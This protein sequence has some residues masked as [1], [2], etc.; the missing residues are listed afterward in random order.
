MIMNLLPYYDFGVVIEKGNKMKYL[1]I[2]SLI[3]FISCE[4][5]NEKGKICGINDPIEDLDWLKSKIDDHL[6]NSPEFE[7]KITQYEY[8]GETVFLAD[9]ALIR[10]DVKMLMYN[11]EGELICT[12]EGNTESDNCPNFFDEA[13]EEELLWHY[14]PNP[15]QS[16]S[17]TI[18]G[19]DMT[20]CACCGGW[21]YEID[22]K[23]YRDWGELTDQELSLID[24]EGELVVDIE[25]YEVDA[26]VGFNPIVVKKINGL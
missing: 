20:L 16:A 24:W 26:C 17:A 7:A 12:K 21:L 10:S 5:D 9:M 2:L 1:I 8:K 4:D 19:F 11:C 22:D 15:I 3:L 6:R 23:V 14:I 13:R 25:Y 18:N